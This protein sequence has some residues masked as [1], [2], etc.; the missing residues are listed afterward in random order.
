M[1]VVHKETKRK[2]VV[3]AILVI[4][5]LRVTNKY[6]D[7]FLMA[8]CAGFLARRSAIRHL[9]DDFLQALHFGNSLHSEPLKIH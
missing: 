9:G 3:V 8:L 2:P 1:L 4:P 6:A 7:Y 5:F